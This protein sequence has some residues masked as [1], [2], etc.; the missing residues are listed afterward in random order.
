MFF[1]FFFF[2]LSLYYQ[3]PFWDSQ[4]PKSSIA[5]TDDWLLLKKQ[6]FRYLV[7][8]SLFLSYASQN[9]QVD[10]QLLQ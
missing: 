10:I 4:T 6:H 8:T 3:G 9:T 7:S 2:I 1:L 5:I